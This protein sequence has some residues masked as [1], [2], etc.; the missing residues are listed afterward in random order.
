MQNSSQVPVRLVHD[1]RLLWF[2]VERPGKGKPKTCKLPATDAPRNG[3]NARRVL[4]PGEFA[5]QAVDPRFYCFAPGKQDVLV[6]T[7]Q[8]TPHYGF[9]NKATR[10]KKAK[11]ASEANPAAGPPPHVA[12]PL[13]DASPVGPLKNVQGDPLIL[14]AR[15]A[16]WSEEP[17]PPKNEPS[18]E[19]V[20]GSDAETERSVTATV[21]L[22]N[23]TGERMKIY[24][25]RDALTFK[26]LAMQGQVECTTDDGSKNPDR[27]AFLGLAPG[28]STSVTTR[29]VELCPRG[30]FS[31][32]GLYQIHAR[33]R[34]T[35]DG[36]DFGFEAYTGTL[37]TRKPATVRIRK[38]L[39]LIPVALRPSAAAPGA[40]AP[41]NPGP[42][43]PVPPPAPPPAPPP[44]PP[45]QG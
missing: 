41:G 19:I 12:Q 45:P 33:L 22:R 27:G 34:A 17:E 7:A 44:P 8:V 1:P 37:E 40:P 5:L 43:P 11:K 30:T 23:T 35:S 4:Q 14:D 26:V 25:R 18:L 29:L 38:T 3:P 9:E 13:D 32:S 16:E 39:H 20:R 36:S 31:E 15:Y 21:R 28:G 2:E 10:K 42:P 6:P 24:F